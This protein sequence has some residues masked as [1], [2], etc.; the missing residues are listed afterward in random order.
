[1]VT[2]DDSVFGG[3]ISRRRFVQ[4]SA[5]AGAGSLLASAP[6]VRA[7]GGPSANGKLQ[8]AL[9]GLGAQGR[10]LLDSLLKIDSIQI[11]AIC[12]IWDLS[13]IHI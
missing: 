2:P 7:Q 3:A 5:A 1:M 8:I 13:L 4:L 10:V 11:V 9:I 6:F 12:D